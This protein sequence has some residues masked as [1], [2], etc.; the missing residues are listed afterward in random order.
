MNSTQKWCLSSLVALTLVG[1]GGGAGE[2]EDLGTISDEVTSGK[3]PDGPTVPG[4]DVSVYQGTIDWNAVKASGQKFAIARVSDGFYL[5]TTFQRNWAA[6]KAAGLIRG[7]YQFF[8]PGAAPIDQANLVIARVGRLGA[9]DL[10]VMLD[11]EVTGGRSPAAITDSIHRWVDAIRAGTGKTP[12]IYT[13]AYFWDGSVGSYDFSSLPLDVAW[14]GTN[15]PGTPNAWGRW[16]MHQYSSTGRV[17]GIAGNVDMNVFNGS[18]AQLQQWAGEN[19]AP[20]KVPCGLNAGQSLVAGQS[21][22][23]CNG[24]IELAMQTDGN[25]VLLERSPARVLWSAGIEGRGGHLAVMQTDGNLVVYTPGGGAVWH[26]HTGGNLGSALAVQDD[27]NLVLY[28]P[29]MVPSWQSNTVAPMAVACG[30]NPGERLGA[31]HSLGSCDGRFELAMQTDGNLVVYQ[32][33]PFRALWSSRTNGR[34]GEVAVMQADGNL[35]VYT[36][37]GRPLWSSRTSGHSGSALAMQNDGNL[38]VYA[39]RSIATWSSGTSGH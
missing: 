26:T 8:E 11:V 23:S 5:D 9:G 24:N 29:G 16:T 37:G 36:A 13:G 2:T 20:V 32:R 12:F 25:L 21:A 30:L 17:P 18:L 6:I 39:P 14:Y 27:G 4:I 28:S 1:C 34:G 33:S 7:A 19:L 3:C 10:P 15:C 35:V 22:T 31:G 38:V